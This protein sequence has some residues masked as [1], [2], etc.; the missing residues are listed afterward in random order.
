[1]QYR[2]NT[3]EM[4][5][6]NV[7]YV[8]MGSGIITPDVRQHVSRAQQAR[9]QGQK[10]AVAMGSGMITPAVRAHIVNGK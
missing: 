3:V 2:T 6:K 4:A 10:A 8:V 9:T 5:L 7:A 1:M